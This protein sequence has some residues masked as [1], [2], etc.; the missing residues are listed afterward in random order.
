MK[1]AGRNVFCRLNGSRKG[2]AI[3][4]EH[5]KEQLYVV[6]LVLFLSH[7]CKQGY[8]NLDSGNPEGCS[9]CFCYGHSATCSSAENYS[10][11]KI[12]SSF[13]QGKNFVVV[14]FFYLRY[15]SPRDKLQALY[16]SISQNLD[17]GFFKK[18]KT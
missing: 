3:N 18:V 5:A 6:L 15:E 2:C 12:T 7:R 9:R 17:T 4:T 11:H 8:Y 14:W 16:K 1:A 13:Q 10:I